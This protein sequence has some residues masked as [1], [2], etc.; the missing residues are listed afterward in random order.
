MLLYATGFTTCLV[1]L[2]TLVVFYIKYLWLKSS[3]NNYFKVYNKSNE[4]LV[5]K[6][7]NN[8]SIC[9]K[10]ITLF[11]QSYNF[12]S[13]FYNVHIDNKVTP[14]LNKLDLN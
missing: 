5:Y 14:M 10:L 8:C 2:I 11:V 12:L 3:Y 9:S 4:Y 1:L 13:N 6:L 7:I